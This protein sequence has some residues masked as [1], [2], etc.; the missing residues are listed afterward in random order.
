M[1]ATALVAEVFHRRFQ[2]R[3]YLASYRGLAPT[4]YASGDSERDHGITKADNQPARSTLVELA[5]DWLRYQPG[6]RLTA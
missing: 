4:P 2:S 3:R 1:T 5:Q 6:S